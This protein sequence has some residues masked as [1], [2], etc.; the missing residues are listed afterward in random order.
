MKILILGHARHGKDTVAEYLSTYYGLSFIS[1][2]MIFAPKMMDLMPGQY[3]TTMECWADRVNHRDVWFKAIRKFCTPD[4]SALAKLIFSQYD[5]YAGV[6]SEDE[7]RSI[8]KDRL[9]DAAIWVD[10][11]ERLPL[12]PWTSMELD[13]GNA[14]YYLNNN[15]DLQYLY[16]CVDALAKQLHLVKLNHPVV[17]DVTTAIQST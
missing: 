8:Y 12:E 11:S 15:K 6:R 3:Q 9:V 16:Q 10:A 13:R 14:S 2:S 7:L 17:M 1:S 4:G 5:I